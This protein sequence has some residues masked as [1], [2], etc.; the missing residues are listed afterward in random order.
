MAAHGSITKFEDVA[1]VCYEDSDG[2]DCYIQSFFA[3][4]IVVRL[5]IFT[6]MCNIAPKLIDGGK[7]LS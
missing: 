2:L 4:N 6:A 7:S 3:Q 1:S 5:Q